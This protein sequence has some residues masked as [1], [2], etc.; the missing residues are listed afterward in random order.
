MSCSYGWRL[1]GKDSN[2]LWRGE[3]RP[4][5]YGECGVP[6]SVPTCLIVFQITVEEEGDIAAFA[7]YTSGA[8]N[9]L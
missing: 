1:L 5:H 7:S 8:G 9:L 4:A 2:Q 3:S 6:V